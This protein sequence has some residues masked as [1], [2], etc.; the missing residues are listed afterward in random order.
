[1]IREHPAFI[2]ASWQI[3]ST[4]E[5]G[6]KGKRCIDSYSAPRGGLAAKYHFS[7]QWEGYAPHNFHKVAIARDHTIWFRHVYTS[8]AWMISISLPFHQPAPST[9][10]SPKLSSKFPNSY[11]TEVQ[12]EHSFAPFAI[13]MFETVLKQQRNLVGSRLQSSKVVSD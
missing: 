13:R 8:T 5:T 6:C 7:D 10:T 2:A 4:F 9:M 1:M 12:E 11:N 3:S